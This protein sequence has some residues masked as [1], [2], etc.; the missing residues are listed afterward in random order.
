MASLASP[1]GPFAKHAEAL[2]KRVR[3]WDSDFFV[4]GSKQHEAFSVPTPDEILPR[5]TTNLDYFCVNYA[6]CLAIFALIAV[7]VYPQL[8]VL[9]CIFSAAWYALLTR[10]GHMKI[11]VGAA[12]I[13]KQHLQMLLAALNSLVVLYLAGSTI[14]A[15]IGASLLVVL[16]HAGFR[17]VPSKAKD[18]LAQGEE[19]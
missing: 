4:F 3:K 11:Q 15:T 19:P 9:V 12:L 8:L 18:K 17:N 10:P 2:L 7:V 1:T 14:F 13:S 16:L 5:I 6:I